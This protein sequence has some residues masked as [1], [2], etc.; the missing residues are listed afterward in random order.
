MSKQEHLYPRCITRDMA[1]TL[2]NRSEWLLS[3]T[4]PPAGHSRPV[5]PSLNKGCFS[6]VPCCFLAAAICGR[7][8]YTDWYR[9]YAY[10]FSRRPEP[11]PLPVNKAGRQC[12]RTM[13]AATPASNTSQQCRQRQRPTN[14][15]PKRTGPACP[16]GQTGPVVL[17]KQLVPIVADGFF[18]HRYRWLPARRQSH[19]QTLSP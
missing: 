2:S 7:G 14:A 8:V 19:R 5:R 1:T 12:W 17:R 16:R 15:R 13:L 6:Q 11:L 18:L 10:R 3:R 9:Y 4:F